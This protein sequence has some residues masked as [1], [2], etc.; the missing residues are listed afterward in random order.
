VGSGAAVGRVGV[1]VGT[2]EFEIIGIGV[3]A[4]DVVGE[5]VG[6]VEILL[7]D[8]SSCTILIDVEVKEHTKNKKGKVLG[9]GMLTP[10]IGMCAF[11][12][13]QHCVSPPFWPQI[14]ARVRKLPCRIKGASSMLS[15][16][17]K[18]PGG[19]INL[20][21]VRYSSRSTRLSPF[22]SA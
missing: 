16:F 20:T 4:R 17:A 10:S 19:P 11:S 8:G 2:A 15:I 13:I 5:V 12:P 18:N 3:G 22:A 6:E 9:S 1:A 14:Q 7:G 21:K